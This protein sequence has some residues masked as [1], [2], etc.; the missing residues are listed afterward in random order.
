[1]DMTLLID[2]LRSFRNDWPNPHVAPADIAIAGLYY[3]G[4]GDRCKCAYCG[5]VLG[6]WD[7]GDIPIRDHF[8][9]FPSCKYMDGYDFDDSW[10]LLKIPRPHQDSAIGDEEDADE[11]ELRV[12]ME[13]LKRNLSNQ[14]LIELALKE[15]HAMIPYET[16]Q[17]VEELMEAITNLEPG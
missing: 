16:F 12:V 9:H 11:K 3:T 14:Q 2:R 13:V 7:R 6:H 10:D 17:S 4:V 5:G 1:M 15:K 8:R